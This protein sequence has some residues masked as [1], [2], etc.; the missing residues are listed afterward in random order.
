M[1]P[2]VS[3]HGIG[4]A[5]DGDA[6]LVEQLLPHLPPFF[7][8]GGEVHAS[9]ALSLTDGWLSADLP[10][11]LSV[12]GP[13][14]AETLRATASRIELVIADRL[15][16]LVAVHAGVVAFEG[17]AIVLPG[18]SMVGKSTLVQALLALGGTYLS[19]EFA[20]LDT[21]G[22]VRPYPRRM[23][24][25]TATGTERTVPDRSAGVSDDPYPVGLVALLHHSPDGWAVEEVTAGQAVLGLVDNC[26]SVRRDPARALAVLGAVAE[27]AR[28]VQG[29]RGE[30]DEAAALLVERAGQQ[31]ETK[32]PWA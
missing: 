9:A 1:H 24:M 16:A 8:V 3:W 10:D 5:L 26:V 27:S 23:T 14:G 21:D 15:P 6:D 2:V 32:P 20:L 25:R 7:D 19:D 31:P 28:T 17:R 11:G 4:V 30:A 22:R 18:R 12:A 13:L 29:S